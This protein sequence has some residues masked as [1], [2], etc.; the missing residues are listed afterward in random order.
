MEKMSYMHPLYE[1]YVIKSIKKYPSLYI[2]TYEYHKN[3]ALRQH[4]K[5]VYNTCMRSISRKHTILKYNP[6]GLFPKVAQYKI[7]LSDEDKNAVYNEIKSKDENLILLL[8]IREVDDI[9]KIS[10]CYSFY[11]MNI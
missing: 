6:D 11:S 1:N 8:D 4:F 2:Y 10:E 9:Y 5:M 3:V 7:K